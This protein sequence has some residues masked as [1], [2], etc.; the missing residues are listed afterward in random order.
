MAVEWLLTASS[1]TGLM[2]DGW[3]CCLGD[4]SGK[5][6][7]E[8]QKFKLTDYSSLGLHADKTVSWLCHNMV[9]LDW[10]SIAVGAIGYAHVLMVSIQVTGHSETA[11]GL[12]GERW[13]QWVVE[14]G[15]D[16][17]R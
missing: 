9:V 17:S 1:L 16:G 7:K 13:G 5:P 11:L 3:F 15:G 4:S 8:H 10:A 14:K 12:D 6:G 2:R